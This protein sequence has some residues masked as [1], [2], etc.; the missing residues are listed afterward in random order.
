VSVWYPAAGAAEAPRVSLA[1]YLGD[2]GTEV[3]FESPPAALRERA[4]RDLQSALSAEGVDLSRLEGA[5]TRK[6]LSVRN[7]SPLV[8]PFPLILFAPGG[9]G[10]P[11][12]N[13][14]IAEFLASHGFVVASIPSLGPRSRQAPTTVE[15]IESSVR[16]LAFALHYMRTYPSVGEM[17]GVLGYSWGGLT[18]SLLAMGDTGIG[19]VASLD[20]SSMVKPHLA[21]ARSTPGFDARALRQPLLML[22]ANAR[23]W[24][25]RTFE[26]FEE[27]SLGEQEAY[28][29]R[30][31]DLRHGDFASTA[32]E[33]VLH[34]LV[35]TDRDV[36]RIDAAFAWQCRYVLA[37]F[38]AHLR[39]GTDGRTFLSQ[40]PAALGVPEGLL[41]VEIR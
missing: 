20:P 28:L 19:A 17:Q 11:S 37:F 3:D 33:L 26:F 8:G 4:L 15:G 36:G 10:S 27:V 13:P 14:V 40:A 25:A 21:T 6:G 23:E 30:F 7:G 29:V 31:N 24:T 39:G 5:L 1:E 41:T 16:D 12:Q 2:A 34:N 18:T 9:G 35:E 32:I 22:I 38:D